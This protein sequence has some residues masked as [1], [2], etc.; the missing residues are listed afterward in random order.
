MLR[1]AADPL[2]P[3]RGEIMPRGPCPASCEPVL[4]KRRRRLFPH[5]RGEPGGLHKVAAVTEFQRE[6]PYPP[7]I[8]GTQHDPQ[9]PVPYFLYAVAR[10]VVRDPAALRRELEHNPQVVGSALVQALVEVLRL[11]TRG[12]LGGV[13]Q[14]L[15]SDHPAHNAQGHTPPGPAPPLP[16]GAPA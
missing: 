12:Y 6:P 2:T 9:P 13:A 16:T 5:R 14:H 15:S 11:G 1:A 4:R 7:G 8:R 3:P 10:V